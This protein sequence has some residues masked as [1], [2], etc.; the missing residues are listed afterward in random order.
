M[1]PNATGR[2]L[3]AVLLPVCRPESLDVD[4]ADTHRPHLVMPARIRWTRTDLAFYPLFGENEGRARRDGTNNDGRPFK[5]VFEAN[6]RRNPL[7][8]CV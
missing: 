4:G 3:A 6:L 2:S 7:L 8:D 1:N 5:A